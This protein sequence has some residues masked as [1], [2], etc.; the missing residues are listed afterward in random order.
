MS[1]QYRTEYV[2][3]QKTVQR[4][5]MEKVQVPKMVQK[6]RV[7]PKFGEFAMHTVT[8]TMRSWLLC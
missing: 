4:T 8:H 2:P 5:V 6:Q 3:Q 1:N 7:I